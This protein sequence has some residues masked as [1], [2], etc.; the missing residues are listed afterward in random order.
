MDALE[1]NIARQEQ[2]QAL[3]LEIMRALDGALFDL[4][5][6][7]DELRRARAEQQRI[8]LDIKSEEEFAAE[9]GIGVDKMRELRQT[10]AL[11]HLRPAHTSIA[12]TAA[13]RLAACERLTR[14]LR[15]RK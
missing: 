11:S 10:L 9:L 2:I 13:Q 12:Y 8:N 4:E 6:D 1:R 14:P 7:A 15:S 3:K 5:A